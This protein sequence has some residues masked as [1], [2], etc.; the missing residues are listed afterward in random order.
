MSRL[1]A[2]ALLLAAAGCHPA[3]PPA[4]PRPPGAPW[5]VTIVVDQ[6]A[7]WIA[8][9]R[10]GALPATGGF[11]RLRR[12]GLYAHQLR[13]A[14]ACTD[15]APGHSALYTGTVPRASGIVANEIL[16]PSGGKSVSVLADPAVRFVVAGRT[17][18]IDRAASSLAALDTETVADAL[19]AA[20]PDARVMSFSLK[21]RGAL[22]AGGR[23]PTLAMWL[24]PDLDAFVTSTAFA[25][26]LPAWVV[27]LASAAAVDRARVAPWKPLE[28]GWLAAHVTTPD[29]QPGE[30]DYDGM[31][32]A[33]PHQAHTAKGE[34]ATPAG[35]ELVLALAGAA[36]AAARAEG[37]GRPLL[38]ALSLSSHDYIAHVFG[39]ESWEAWDEL[40]RVDAGLAALFATL[41]R[42]V[43]PDGYAVM[44]TGDHGSDP[45]PERA[46]SGAA[47]WCRGGAPDPWQRPCGEGRRLEAPEVVAALEQAAVTTLGSAPGGGPWIAGI[48]EPFVVF[49]QH[50]RALTPGRRGRLVAAARA[51]ARERFAVADLVD[52]RTLRGSCP[53]GDG[54]AALVCR[55]TRPQGPGD[56]YVVPRMGTFFDPGLAKGSGTSHGSP[57]LYDRAVPL[58]IRAPGRVPAGAT[59]DEPVAFD[60]FART[61]A[62]LLDAPPPAGA[63]DAENLVRR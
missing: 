6:L 56:L 17:D 36:A 37:D 10:L 57:Y 39:P 1:V 62:A 55:C 51:V 4:T 33:F 23:R 59:R 61:A 18:A 40:L 58:L 42:L 60:A 19:V 27:P 20:R 48:S 32:V 43:G 3:P 30:G 5:L 31:G 53:A 44:L 2:A 41:D 24:D 16:P 11:A 14:H 22:F 25:T 7:A 46:A 52:V 45:L 49:G 21:D 34:R 63:R 9:E 38:L 50:G 26:A 47:P 54:V 8:D 29:P 28:T 15:T 35:D 12:E 13:F